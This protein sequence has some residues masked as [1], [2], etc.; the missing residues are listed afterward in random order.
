MLLNLSLVVVLYKTGKINNWT[1]YPIFRAAAKSI[2][3]GP[4]GGN[5]LGEY[6]AEA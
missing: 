3:L 6:E 2:Y 1:E 5:V 4:V